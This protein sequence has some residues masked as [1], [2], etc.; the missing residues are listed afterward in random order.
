[1]SEAPR[2]ADGSIERVFKEEYGRAV[3]VLVRAFSDIDLAEE[4]VQDAFTVAME[5]WPPMDFRPVL[6]AGLSPRLATGRSIDFDA[7]RP[8]RLGMLRQ[9]S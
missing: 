3:A 9:C 8:E 1:M 7:S 4:A 5:R 2:A 6:P